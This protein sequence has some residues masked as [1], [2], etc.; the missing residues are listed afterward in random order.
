MVERRSPKPKVVGSSPI[1]PAIYNNIM[2]SLAGLL[3]YFGQVKNEFKYIR[4]ISKKEL[5][6][7]SI[8]VLTCVVIFAVVFSLFDLLVSTVV[9]LI[10]GF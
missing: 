6:Q 3:N 2:K 8:L 5:Y 10:V 9:K 4:F 1:A 7:I